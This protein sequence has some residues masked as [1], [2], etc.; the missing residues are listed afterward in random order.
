MYGNKLNRVHNIKNKM[1]K[2]KF[3]KWWQ[4]KFH[5]WVVPF[6]YSMVW[7][8]AVL[9][10][11]CVDICSLTEKQ[12][13]LVVT[14]PVILV[15][16]FELSIAYLD[17]FTIHKNQFVKIDFVVYVG[18]F[19]L[20]LGITL[21]PLFCYHFT[22]SRVLLWVTLIPAIFLKYAEMWLFNNFDRF[23][24]SVSKEDNGCGFQ[25]EQ[26]VKTLGKGYEREK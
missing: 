15:A 18:S 5:P 12:Q 16:I 26:Q 24:L 17:F 25:T 13:V 1:G 19:F 2:S 7:F 8:L 6:L 22:G 20:L 4:E 10:S 14:L 3:C 23:C 9:I 21:T 11:L